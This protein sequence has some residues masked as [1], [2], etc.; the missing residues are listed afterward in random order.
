MTVKL[1]SR[2]SKNYIFNSFIR[3]IIMKVFTCNSLTRNCIVNLLI[4]NVLRKVWTCFFY[5]FKR[6]ETLS[7][8]KPCTGNGYPRV[9]PLALNPPPSTST[10]IGLHYWNTF[11]FVL[12]IYATNYI[13]EEQ[14]KKSFPTQSKRRKDFVFSLFT[15]PNLD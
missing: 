1:T 12:Q 7:A 14:I 15:K 6:F 4:M 2:N 11:V 3:F 8:V 9:L 13:M 5:F 10:K